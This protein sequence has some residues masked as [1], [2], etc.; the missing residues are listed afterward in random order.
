ML[1]DERRYQ[2]LYLV[3]YAAGNGIAG[4]RN[5][6]FEDIGLSESQ[7][8][9]IGA[10]LVG[11]GIV[12]QPIWGM[13]ADAYGRT[14][15][16]MAIGAVVSILGGLL[17]PLGMVIESPFVLMV[18]AAGIYSAFRSPIVPL[19]N[20][21]VLSSGIDYGNV[22]AFGSIAF[23]VGILA[24]G[25]L[26]ETFGTATIFAVYA[27]G[28]VV[29]VISLRG[30]PKPPASELSPDLR[31][32]SLQLLT[33]PA[34][35][36]L[37]AVGLLIGASTTTAN[38]FFS[39]YIR[40]IEA[41]D[42]MTGA[43]WFVRTLA[44]AAVFVWIVR[45]GWRHRTQLLVGAIVLALSFV[46]YVVPGT[47]PAVFLAQVPQGAGFA[48]F[49]LASVSLAH[50]YAPDAMSASAQ[51]LL[52]ALGLGTGRVFGQVVGGWIANLVGVQDMY[53]FVVLGTGLAALLTVGFFHRGIRAT[54]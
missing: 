49:T 40:A 12:A 38:S 30:L 11:A 32:D 53:I 37:L 5:I 4:Y 9:L 39:V 51:A 13:V 7:M 36:L 14:K 18:V 19:A 8:G 44:E 41:S 42:A 25:P 54:Q 26:V 23:G 21:M 47:L 17:F 46:L 20:S 10:V 1:S 6:F 29:F 43:A 27:I 31:E 3:L 35:V 52:A 28:M 24:L 2:L 34:F 48:L 50:E 33:K 45:L 16:A 22:R 15:L